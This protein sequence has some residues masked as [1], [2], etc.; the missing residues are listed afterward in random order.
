MKSRRYGL[1]LAVAALT[2]LPALALAHDGATV[3][4][5]VTDDKGQP[6]ANVQVIAQAKTLPGRVTTQTAASGHYALHALPDGEYVL[7]FQRE[8]LVVHKIA[9][10]V[11]GGELLT[12]DV[13]LVPADQRS[14]APEPIVVKVQDREAFMRHPLMANTY[15]RDRIDMMPVL[16]TATSVLELT[17]GTITTSPFEPMV[18]LDDRPVLLAWPDRRLSLPIDFGRAS[19]EEVTALRASVPVVFDQGEGGAVQIAP[20]RGADH[21]TGSFQLVGGAAGAQADQAARARD[22]SNGIGTVEATFGGPALRGQTWFFTAF[23]VDRPNVSE[24]TALVG[25]PFESRIHTSSFFGR[26]THRFGSQHRIDGSFSR[27]GTASEQALLDGWRVADITAA[28]TDD[29]SQAMWA[30]RTSSQLG[31]ATFLE[32]RATGEA[33]S[34]EAP[35][36]DVTTLESHTAVVDLPARL[37]LA[38]PRGC[39]GCE[40]SRRSVLGG[41]AVLHH[42]FGV[43]AQSH[44]LVAGYELTRYRERPAVQSAA[45][46]E[47]LASRTI[48]AGNAAIP[49]VV[50]N[51]SSAVAWFPEFDSDLDGRAQSIFVGDRWRSAGNLTVDAG[52]RLDWWRLTAANGANVLDEWTLSPRVQIAWDPPG[53][54]E[55]R[56]TG[57]FAQYAAG[58]PWRTDDLSLATDLAWRRLQYAGPALNNG[59][60][61][62]STPATLAQVASWFAGA[63]GTAIAP[64]A[65]IVPG[66][67]TVAEERSRGPQTTELAGGVGGRIRRIELRSDLVWRHSGAL[68]ARLATP[69]TFAV[70]ELGQAIDTGTPELRD[71]LWRKST[72]LSVQGLYRIGLQASAGASYTL[73]HLWGTADDRLGDDPAQRL[74]FGYPAYFDEAWAAPA[75]DLRRDRRHRANLWLITQPIENESIGRLSVG[76]LWRLESGT[77]YGAVGWIDTRPYVTNPGVQQPPV[78]VPYYFTARDAFRSDGLSRSDLSIQFARAVPGMLRGEWFVRADILNLF[79]DTATLDPWRS[80]GVV[81]ALQDPSRFA[82]F[83]PFVTQPVEGVHW[84][85]DSRF[86]SE[87]SAFRTMP[88]SF[89]WFVGIRF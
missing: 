8:N 80:A 74:A 29:T 7:T 23:A 65:A 41:R 34:L 16:G 3:R 85:L 88:R 28:T 87:T 33:L 20:R 38:A 24:E 71:G 58:L 13:S 32:L 56:W 82:P 2:M 79:D 68:R 36:P 57:S 61:V 35:A 77:P 6:L 12:L 81:T 52:V 9:G 39:L 75:G 46:M 50:P 63:G 45:R 54:H 59:G 43:G 67:T 31:G 22:T 17:P 83:N 42:L 84:A 11:S 5:R 47:L 1:V 21:W 53:A 78:A 66:I 19:L 51:G 25:A 14:G 15:R 76:F 55:L 4:G 10:S 62:L 40:P 30:V 27:V 86:P 48:L 60:A 73:A 49:V 44:D 72:E 69:G 26:L 70:D 18:W 37:G 89:R 64:A